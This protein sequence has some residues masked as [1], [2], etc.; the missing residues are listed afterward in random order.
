MTF[1]EQEKLLRDAFE[2][3]IHNT[4]DAETIRR[5]A[6]FMA[7]VLDC[8]SAIAIPPAKLAEIIEISRQA[9][10]QQVD[11]YTEKLAEIKANLNNFKS[12]G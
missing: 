12:V 6:L 1:T 4:T 7:Q 5:R 10:Y 2:V 8:P 11:T 3:V 9:V